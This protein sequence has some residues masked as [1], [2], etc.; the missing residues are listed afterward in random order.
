MD[1][2]KSRRADID[3]GMLMS[4][5]F[6]RSWEHDLSKLEREAMPFLIQGIKDPGV[7]SKISRGD[8]VDVI[9][10]PTPEML[11]I[12]KMI[13]KYMEESHT[14]LEEHFEG[15]G[16]KKDYITQLWKLPPEARGKGFGNFMAKRKIPSIEDGINQGL[17]PRTLDV[18]EIVRVYDRFKVRTAYNKVFANELLRMVDEDGSPLIQKGKESTE[19]LED[20]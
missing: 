14:F 12:K 9:K 2:I 7:L 1:L 16:Y 13:G 18:A 20:C 11:R 3:K 6:V 8:L 19:K 10:N 17:E 4:E 15:L 5:A